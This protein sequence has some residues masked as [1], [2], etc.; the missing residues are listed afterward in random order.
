MLSKISL[1]LLVNAL[2]VSVIVSG[3]SIRGQDSSTERKQ[4]GVK[5]DRQLQTKATVD[6]ECTVSNFATAVGG[7]ATLA[8]LLSVSDDAN[9]IQ[10]KLDGLCGAAR[11]PSL[12]LSEAIGEGPQF[13]KNFLDGGTTWNDNYEADGKYILS[14]DAAI[15]PTLYDSKATNT[16]FSAPDGGANAE[17]E[18]YF[19]NF[20]NGDQEC[21]L[22]VIEC[23]YTASRSYPDQ[24]GLEDNAQM[25]ALD[26]TLAAK[27]NHIQ[28][29][30]FKPSFTYYGT[31]AQDDTYCSGFAYD[32]DS[33]GDAVKYNTL[34]HMAMMTNLYTKNYVKNIP[35]AP[36][37]GCLEQMPVVD[38]AA[39]V[40]EKE[41]YEIDL[42]TGDINV[43]ISWE[44]CGTN[45]DL[46]SY[47]EALPGRSAFEKTF[48]REKIVGTDNCEAA[49]ESF[50]NE[51]MYKKSAQ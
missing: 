14:Q 35:G 20:F 34:F 33:F 44:E 8:S 41:G 1:C 36:M 32:E 6:G 27:S 28:S 9:D 2:S 24:T 31:K 26:L 21:R 38:N 18:H 25:C 4:A 46:Y 40:K 22:G 15:I 7:Q 48:V 50:M 12:D 43:D 39:C 23:C 42:S 11:E 30:D 16:V 49:A 5:A 47:Y 3:K 37:C 13:L 45:V 17:Y 51:Q 10:A 29:P 19:S